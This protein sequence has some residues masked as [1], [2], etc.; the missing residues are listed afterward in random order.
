MAVAKVGHVG[1]AVEMLG[2]FPTYGIK[3]KDVYAAWLRDRSAADKPP[4]IIP[5]HGSIV[6]SENV[7]TDE[8]S[9][10]AS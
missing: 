2:T 6:R 8:I 5:C 1:Q 10:L 9:L 7:A 3:D 4:M